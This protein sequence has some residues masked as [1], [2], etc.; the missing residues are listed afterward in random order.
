MADNLQAE[1]I[2]TDEQ[3]AKAQEMLSI[4]TRNYYVKA[5]SDAADD[6]SSVCSILSEVY[7]PSADELGKPYLMYAK[8]LIALGQD[9]NKLMDIPEEEEEDDQDEEEDDEGESEGASA[10]VGN[11]E[12]GKEEETPAGAVEKTAPPSSEQPVDLAQ[13][14]SSTGITRS[15]VD[16]TETTTAD[17]EDDVANLQVAWEVLELAVGIFSRQPSRSKEL[18]E[19]YIELAGISF[20]NSNFEAAIKDF[21][22]ALDVLQNL[23]EKDSREFAEISYKIGLAYT[24]LNMFDEARISLLK[25]CG[26]LDEVIM[27]E[28]RKEPRTEEVESA[29]VDLKETKAEI[30]NKIAEVDDY[31]QQSMD[32]VKRELA[33]LVGPESFGEPAAASG[34][35][36]SSSSK[37]AADI[38][39]LIK[40]KRP[41]E[42]PPSKTAANDITHLVKR[43][44]D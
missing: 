37:P 4:A 40:R 3:I 13:P 31:K 5:Y 19:S 6:F 10:A 27:A 39:H 12:E 14:G 41:D 38:S 43:K 36:S 18:A 17:D 26:Y 33:K 28:E 35:G 24:M 11:A 16:G 2:S 32:E 7:G 15:A 25:A 44:K 30:E 23:P 34:E 9:E 21:K 20:E 8:C 42:G 1:Q 22:Q 29:I